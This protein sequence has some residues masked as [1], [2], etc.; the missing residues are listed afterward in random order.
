MYIFTCD[1]SSPGKSP[2]CMIRACFWNFNMP[3]KQFFI[4][5]MYFFVHSKLLNMSCNYFFFVF[6]YTFLQIFLVKTFSYIILNVESVN[7]DKKGKCSEVGIHMERRVLSFSWK[8][9]HL[10]SISINNLS[11][12]SDNAGAQ[13]HLKWPPS[14]NCFPSLKKTASS[15]WTVSIKN[16]QINLGLFLQ[17]D[18]FQR[19]GSRSCFDSD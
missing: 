8:M 14:S 19:F 7:P 12:C 9:Y 5:F 6:F 13:Q 15:Q 3:T 17:K 11:V 10:L 4:L 2:F 1:L 16:M 18:F